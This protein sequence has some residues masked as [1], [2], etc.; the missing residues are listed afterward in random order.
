MEDSSGARDVGD[1]TSYLSGDRPK[2]SMVEDRLG[3]ARFA[4]ALARSI[5]RLTP[6]ATIG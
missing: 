3:Y 2:E 4:Q 5:S 1:E 6:I